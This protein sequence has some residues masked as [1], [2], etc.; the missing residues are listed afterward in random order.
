MKHS[1]IHE[2]SR[3]SSF[4][5]NKVHY[6]FYLFFVSILIFG[7]SSD[8]DDPVVLDTNKQITSFQFT[9]SDNS[10]IKVDV[11]GVIDQPNAS[12]ILKVPS[13]T[14][15]TALKPTIITSEKASV[16][17]SSKETQDFSNP[18]TYVV[19][20]E[21]GSKQSYKVAVSIVQDDIKAINKFVFL[22][23]NNN[24]VLTTDVEAVINEDTK[25]I[26]LTVPTGTNVTALKPEITIEG[27]NISPA[28]NVAQ[29]FSNPV[30]YVVTAAD[31]SKQSYEVTVSIMSSDTKTINKFVFLAANNNT[32]L[33]ADVEAVINEDTKTIALTVPTGTNVTAL[34][35]EITIAG[36]N[37]SPA[38]NVAQN[39]S[40]PVTYVVTAADGSKQSYEVTVSI[41]NSDTKTI[42]K[43]VF[44][45]ANNNTVLTADIEAVINEDT[46]TIA[47]TVPAGT[48]VT[49]L[50]PEIT[51]EGSNIS[52]ANNVAQNFSNPV[53]YIVTAADGSKQSYVVEVTINM[54][55]SERE[56][57][58]EFY[59]ANPGNTLGW[60][61]NQGMDTWDG[62]RLDGNKVTALRVI[63]KNITV[64]PFSIGELTDLEDLDLYENKLTSVPSSIG[65]LVKLTHLAFSYNDLTSVPEEIGNLTA[66]GGLYFENNELT[67]LPDSIRNLTNLKELQILNN[68]FTTFPDWI[69]DMVNLESLYVNGN[70]LTNVPEE[71]GNLTKLN[72][73]NLTDNNL[74]TIPQAI[75]DLEPNGTIIDKDPGVTC[76]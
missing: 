23:A 71:L 55:L 35:P 61:L 12:I 69:V 27:S 8:D 33:T 3:A 30:T 5:Y 14:V 53:N 11:I 32:V 51:I 37:I 40:N 54:V 20:A 9:E 72:Y 62:V 50:K 25:T 7:C 38:N 22:A 2:K 49:A 24:T 67:D 52:P 58:I 29:N 4:F 1:L 15:V 66:L 68:K 42:N 48:N 76:L 31:G 59:N 73:L 19:T 34:K 21:D 6:Y 16:T 46:K 47:L 13:G 10:D 44:L 39:F 26:A 75:C 17:P 56:I 43:F 63:S 36:T 41:M 65:N 74:T 57:L 60:D 64:L 45:A 28:N 18:V 70:E